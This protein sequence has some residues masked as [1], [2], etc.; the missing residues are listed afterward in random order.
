MYVGLFVSAILGFGLA[1]M[2]DG[3]ERILVP[4]KRAQT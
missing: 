3:L 2:L 4:W 1:A